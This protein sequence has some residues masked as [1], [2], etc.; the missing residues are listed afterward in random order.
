M[1]IGPRLPLHDGENCP[2][3]GVYVFVENR[4]NQSIWG[5]GTCGSRKASGRVGTGQETI[6]RDEIQE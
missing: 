2:C 4:N 3:G 1:S 6:E 5:C